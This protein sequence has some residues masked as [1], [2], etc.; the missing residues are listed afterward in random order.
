MYRDIKNLGLKIE[1]TAPATNE[2]IQDFESKLSVRLGEAYKKFLQE[3]GTLEVKYLEFY[4][5]FKDNAGLPS[6]IN[7]TLYAR[8]TIENFP[9]DLIVF[10]ESGDGTFYCVNE[11]DDVFM[12]N[13]NR[14]QK[15]N[16]SFKA[17]ITNKIKSLAE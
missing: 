2:N 15:I 1:S 16:E 10:Y 17:F 8:D 12:C 7:A 11:R 3:F 4:G 14:C 13:Y 6:A 5:Y 9:E